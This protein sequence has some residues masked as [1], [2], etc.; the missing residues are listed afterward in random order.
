MSIGGAQKGSI[1]DYYHEIS[2]G[3]R[4]HMFD[5]SLAREESKTNTKNAVLDTTSRL[6]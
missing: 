5:N 3:N 4:I 6:A 2:S 1:L